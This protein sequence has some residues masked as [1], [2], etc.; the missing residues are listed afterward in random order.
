MLTTDTI[1]TPRAPSNARIVHIEDVTAEEAR[2]IVLEALGRAGFSV[3]AEIDL[4]DLLRRRIDL[5]LEPHFVLEICRAELAGR[6]LAVSSDA[7][8]LIPCKIA[9][10]KEGRGAAVGML[11]PI[12]V[13]PLLGHEHLGVIAAEVEDRLE[14]V[15]EAVAKAPPRPHRPT[16]A[17]R[18]QSL[19]LDDGER[20]ALVAAVRG[21][22]EGLMAEAA[23]TEKHELQHELAR[24]VDQLEAILRKLDAPG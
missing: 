16:P 1:P 20:V 2:N 9:V 19:I 12:Q 6:A 11:P 8:L 5:D 3:L 14:G 22:I 15:L 7:S 4:A 10:W 17:P 18:R 23:G 24:D 21:R 13:A